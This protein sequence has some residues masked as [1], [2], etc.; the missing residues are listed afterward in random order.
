MTEE[1][2]S[3]EPAPPA[4]FWSGWD[5]LISLAGS[6]L[7]FALGLLLLNFGAQRLGE[8]S[9]LQRTISLYWS[10]GL[11]FLEGA[12]LLGGVFLFGLRRRWTSWKE[13]FGARLS[14]RW[15]L[16][17]Q[18]SGVL[19]IFASS[20]AAGAIQAVLRRTPYNPQ[21]DFLA[22]GG[23]S[24]PALLG[25][26]ATGG[27]IAPLAEEVFFRGLLHRWLRQRMGFWPAA[28]L[29]ALLFGVVHVEISVAGAAFLLGLLLA[30]LYE[31]SGSLWAP[32]I[33]H[34][35]NNAVKIIFLYI[36]LY[37][38]IPITG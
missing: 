34:I 27:L 23:F 13:V 36:I 15:N 35:I 26:L 21:L 19:A 30:W 5:V 33:V 20:L 28:F 8:T 18:I 12:A 17:A 24:W 1:A 3:F 4:R 31:R 9:Y 10:V 25:M 6:G 38:G 14:R 32:I 37:L 11:G 22:P 2:L 29:S 16:V 7:I